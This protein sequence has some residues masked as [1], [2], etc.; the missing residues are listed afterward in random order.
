M[1]HQNRQ[2][3][4]TNTKRIAV[5]CLTALL[6]GGPM[7]AQTQNWTLKACID[8]AL[9]KNI[10]V[11][12]AQLGIEKSERYVDQSQAS[13]LPSLGASA[14]QNLSWEKQATAYDTYQNNHSTSLSV[15]SSM[16][17]YNGGKI[18][19]QIEQTKLQLASSVLSTETVKESVSLSV[20]QLYLQVL[21]AKEQV[22]VAKEQLAATEKQLVLAEERLKLG[23]ASKSDYLQIKSAVAADRL[24]LANAEST[25]AMAKVDLMQMMELPVSDNFEVD[26]PTWADD[27]DKQL[28]PNVQ[29]AYAE[30]LAAKPEVKNAALNTRSAQLDQTI[31][32]AGYY[33]TLSLDGSVGTS[34]SGNISGYSFSEQL[35]NHFSPALGLTLSVPIFQKKQTKTS[36]AIAKLSV[37]EAQLSE[38]DTRNQLRKEVEQ[39]CLDVTTGQVKYRAGLD[40]FQSNEEAYQVAA[41][42]YKLGMMNA[43]DLLFQK[44]SLTSAQSQLLQNKYNLLFAYKILDFYRGLPLN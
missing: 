27:V 10:T 8:Y 40:Q 41:E 31:A 17:L 39:A 2:T 14:R 12:K 35:N 43:V 36:V 21:Y 16:N 13:R 4:T 23:D 44:N 25:L 26:G 1:G 22:Q 30:A 6:L 28:A 15:S 38:I 37:T 32:K 3:M 9:E 5:T 18:N 7:A 42:K 24:S 33:P 20:A 19:A 34:Y 11:Q 29:T